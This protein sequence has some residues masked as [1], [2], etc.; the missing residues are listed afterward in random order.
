MR[1]T[2]QRSSDA[3]WGPS[4]LGQRVTKCH[5]WNLAIHEDTLRLALNDASE[6]ISISGIT[7]V[8]ST[9]GFAWSTIDI[10]HPRR[11]IRLRG[12]PNRQA[13]SLTETLNAARAALEYRRLVAALTT[14]FDAALESLQAW[15]V[16][17]RAAIAETLVEQGWLTTEFFASWSLRKR[18]LA[19]SWLLH[20]PV[21][22]DEI[23]R[24]DHQESLAAW[25]QDLGLL[26]AS[27]NE[28]HLREQAET[29]RDFFQSIE[30]SP[31]TDE[32][33]RAV[34]THDN[35]VLVIASAGSGKTSTMVAKAGYAIKRQ[36]T[37]PDKILMLAFNASA[38]EELQDR[39]RERLTPL[40]LDASKVIARTFHSFALT[41]IGQATGHKPSAAP[42]LTNGDDIRQLG[43]IVDK[44]RRTD[45]GFRASWDFFQTV[46]ARDYVRVSSRPTD[47]IDDGPNLRTAK[48]ELVKS[49]GERIIADWL[50]LN[51]VEYVYEHRYPIETADPEHGQYHPDFYY[52]QIDAYHEH[53]ALNADGTS[54]FEGYVESMEWKR[55]LHRA[56][57]TVLLETTM[58]ELWAGQALGSLAQQLTDRGIHLD[59]RPERFNTIRTPVENEQLLRTF[60][61]FLSHSKSNRLS[62]EQ[63]EAR[64]HADKDGAVR[65]RDQAF[66]RLFIAIRREW[67]EAL[68]SVG[69][70]DFDDMLNMAIDHLQAGDWI[71]PFELVMVDEFQDASLAR[72]RMAN[73]LV[74]R[75]G[76]HLFA[77]GDDWQS[78]NRFAGA[79]PSAMTKFH[80]HFG[81][82]QV[83][84]LERTFR[85]PQSLADV[86]S[87][88]VLRNPDQLA[89]T[90]RSSTEEFPHSVRI[91][92]LDGARNDALEA[93]K[94]KA[95]RYF[96]K[97]L[98]DELLAGEVANAAGRK[99][100]VFVLGRYQH[101]KNLIPDWRDLSS[102]LD[103]RFM[104]A[105]ASKGTEADYVIVP[106]VVSGRWGFPS[107]IQ[108]D[109]VLRIAMPDP[110]DFPYAEERR[111][112]YVALT[113][114]RRQ[115]LILTTTGRES[116]FVLELIRDNRLV[117]TNAIG[118][119]LETIVCPECGRG[120][121]TL[122]D[123]KRGAFLGCTRYPRCKSTAPRP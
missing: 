22:A 100:S 87:S 57:G 78:I 118:E 38:A 61:A 10:A 117:R 13:H 26:I 44:L 30:K 90:V 109:P 110:E 106:D 113:R 102:E 28:T 88:F 34:I 66:V 68:Q 111:L 70:I 67:N 77:V 65:F 21:V 45:Y 8:T 4:L 112:F 115:A 43:R 19:L 95:I 69:A 71:S 79:D 92:T 50:Y 29:N 6:E 36:L 14:E 25:H 72:V 101:Q 7:G 64:L 98:H 2:S 123:G 86:S 1:R 17:L 46:L 42:W 63:L 99:I 49:V 120:I 58:A 105:H 41:V 104:T 103:V 3:N 39:V 47:E 24:P 33:T 89:K 48:G 53:W 108:D 35:R 16:A 81:A 52:P 119:P 32:Q 97:T 40:G 84:K 27:A 85:F 23:L 12:I 91:V 94:R 54:D 107:T 55:D 93:A 60:R 59:P 51:G 96:L 82:A 83:L 20:H 37:D 75:P 62:D 114:A 15:N 73:A 18:E 31:L 5:S 122:R 9:K 116:H 11:R 56:S 76:R 121:M 80:E 74:N